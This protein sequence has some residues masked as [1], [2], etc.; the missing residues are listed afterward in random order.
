MKWKFGLSSS[1]FF[2]CFFAQLVLIWRLQVEALDE[3]GLKRALIAFEKKVSANTMLRLKFA[4]DP[5][6][7]ILARRKLALAAGFF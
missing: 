4:K 3:A 7:F 2:V 6:R 5:Q 1:F